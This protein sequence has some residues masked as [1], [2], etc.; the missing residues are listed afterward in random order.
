MLTRVTD[1]SGVNAI[2]N[3][4]SVRPWVADVAEGE[5]DVSD[6]VSNPAN[7]TLLGDHGAFFCFKYTMGVYEVHTAIRREGRG[8]WARE[9]A[10]AGARYMFAETDCVEL[11][12]RVPQGHVAAK[13]LTEA[14]GFDFQFETPP[15]CVF[16]G[17]KVPAR[18]Y[19]LTLQKWFPRADG[20]EESGA[21]F[22]AWL[23]KRV[24]DGAPHEP[25]PAHSRIVG[26][27]MAMILGGQVRKGVVFYNTRSFAARHATIT[28]LNETPPMIRFDAGVLTVQDGQVRFERAN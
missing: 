13:A 17:Q 23:N 20:M 4:P 26:V 11:L 5:I 10:E 19:S 25:D 9:F 16:K 18:V 1:A 7:A 21:E 6:R 12:T 15:E 22:H 8:E 2:L 24:G 3:D 28:L 27:T 14:M